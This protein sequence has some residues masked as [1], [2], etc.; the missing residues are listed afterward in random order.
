[1]AKGAFSRLLLKAIGWKPVGEMQPE[2]KNIYLFAPHT[3][4]W[5]FALGFLYGR[6]QGHRLKV[7]IKKEAFFFPL[8]PVLRAMGGFPI[9]RSN[10]RATLLSVIHEMERS[11][12]GCFDL[13]ICPEGTRKAIKRWKTGYHTIACATGARV[14]LTFADYR[15]KMVGVKPEGAVMELTDNA[16]SDTDRIQAIYGT[17]ELTGLHPGDFTT[18]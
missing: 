10:A 1:M 15:R 12:Q 2:G 9:D 8:G 7:M 18:E 16:R 11:K 5:D 6:S 3:S 4:I 14:I 13:A 17:M